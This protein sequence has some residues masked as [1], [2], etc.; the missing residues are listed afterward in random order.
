MNVVR[1]VSLVFGWM[2]ACLN[3]A[4]LLQADELSLQYDSA[5]IKVSLPTENEPKVA[6]FGKDSL[7]A[8]AKYLED[9]AL[10]WAQGRACVN[11]HTTGPYLADRTEWM[12]QFGPPNA[13]VVASFAAAVPSQVSAVEAVEKSGHSY[14]PG[15]FSA[16]WRSLGLAQVDRY[17]AGTTTEL[18]DR[19]LRDMFAR[20]SPSG[21]FVSHGEVEIPHITTDFELSLQAARAITAAPGWLSGLEQSTTNAELLHQ[22]ALFKQ[23][24]RTAPPQN[25]FD[26][27]LRLQLISYFPEL[28]THE[29]REQALNLL[30]ARQHN[31]GGWSIRDMSRLEDWHFE[32][33][34][35]VRELVEGLPDAAEPDSDPYMTALAIVLMRQADVSTSD[36]R[37]QRGL[38]WLKREQRVSG[39]WWMHSLYRGNYHYITYIAT[40]EALKAFQLCG[41]LDG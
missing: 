27:V 20:Q 7:Q 8:A 29:Q 28:V 15:T 14:Y 6:Q 34:P 13:A 24:L 30:T 22:I 4:F 16:V 12:A 41:E 10:A 25:D 32:I 18:T 38:D 26:R 17:V 3:P 5:D 35:K 40:V 37:I 31:D 36:P 33:S 39:R 1:C 21:A 9:G 2:F 11:C 23:W 19:S